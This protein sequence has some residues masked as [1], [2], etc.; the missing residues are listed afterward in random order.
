MLSI[1]L[2]L[3][4]FLD[5][6]LPQVCLYLSKLRYLLNCLEISLALIFELFHFSHELMVHLLV[7]HS[8]LAMQS[9]DLVDFSLELQPQI[10]LFSKSL[11]SG[12]IL[13]KQHCFLIFQIYVFLP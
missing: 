6:L 13:I 11:L 5:Q 10:D 8:Q 7:F 9:I 12:T 4:F 2:L 3:L 1:A